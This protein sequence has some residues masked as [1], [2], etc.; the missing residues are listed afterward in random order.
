MHAWGWLACAG[1]GQEQQAEQ[2]GR[3]IE[4]QVH[5]GPCGARSQLP[6]AAGNSPTHRRVVAG[7]AVH[8]AYDNAVI[9][10]HADPGAIHGVAIGVDDDAGLAANLV[11]TT[12]P[13]DGEEAGEGGGGRVARPQGR[14]S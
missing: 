10:D 6:P 3:R 13:G 8:G 11:A 2:A 7:A 12:A 14:V 9:A 1:G 4:R 5:L